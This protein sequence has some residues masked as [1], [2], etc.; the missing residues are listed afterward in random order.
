MMYDTFYRILVFI[1]LLTVKSFIDEYFKY[2]EI[3]NVRL[4]KIYNRFHCNNLVNIG[5]IREMSRE[6]MLVGIR[7]TRG[8]GGDPV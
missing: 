8:T 2:F 1:F 6:I 3:K 5:K 7:I 4:P